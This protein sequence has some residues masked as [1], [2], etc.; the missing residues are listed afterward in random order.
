MQR[1]VIEYL[2]KSAEKYPDKIALKDDKTAITFSE[3]DRCARKI[4]VALSKKIE[5]QKNVPVAVY[6]EKSIN[7]IIAFMGILYSG[8]YYSPIDVHSPQDRIRLV[9]QALQPRVI[10]ADESASKSIDSTSNIDLNDILFIE[11]TQTVDASKYDP[12]EVNNTILDVDPVYVLFTSGSTGVPKGVVINHK[13]V[14]DYTEWLSDTFSFDEHTVFGNQAPFYFDNSILDIYQTMRNG[15]T[16]VIIP[17]HLFMFHSKLIQFMNEMHINTVFWVPSALISV[18]N[19]GIL[20]RERINELEKV[21]FCGEVMPVKPFNEWKRNY[22]DVM[23]ANLYGP[24]EITDVCSYYIV[25]REFEDT[26]SLPIGKACRNTQ[27]VVLNEENEL[28][29]QGEAGE[30][31][32]RGTCLSLGYYGDFTKSDAAFVQNPLNNK[33]RDLLYRTGDIV[34]YNEKDEIIY[35]CRKDSQIKYQ[36]HRIELGEI[37]SAGYSI[38]GIRQ[39]CAIYDGSKIIFFCSLTTE[40]TEKQIY[41]ELKN[42]VPKYMLPKVIR[43]M[44]DIPLNVNGKIDRVYLKKMTE[45]MN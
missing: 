21:L 23:Y 29:K 11:E 12:A 30:L 8:N 1:N 5:G 32:V 33:Y 17:E 28:V 14:I 20:E 2:Q 38:D 7:C 19:S 39:A 26:E 13:A 3:L 44:E 16:L 37:D 42:K 31:C 41:A 4:A 25:D 36:G 27:I 9:L 18:A 40:L 43:I 15:S 45:N 35:L 10:L 6:M 34:K 22:P 24:T